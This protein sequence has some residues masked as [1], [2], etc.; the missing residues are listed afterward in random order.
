[1]TNLQYLLS[2]LSEE[3]IEVAHA[4]LKASQFGL[5]SQDP[6]T[7]ETIQEKLESELND[8]EGV[9]A[10][11]RQET[12][13]DFKSCSQRITD[14]IIRLKKHRIMA[15]ANGLMNEDISGRDLFN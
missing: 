13:F 12:E 7:G 2:R 10:L 6:R 15:K 8:L 9:L 3:C 1:M 11:L 4:A 14:K 5:D